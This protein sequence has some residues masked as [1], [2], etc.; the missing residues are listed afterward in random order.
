MKLYYLDNKFI[1][2]VTIH[3]SYFTG[4]IEYNSGTKNWY[5][6]GY[7]HREYGPA[8]EW[9]SGTKE[10][11]NKGKRHRIDGP[12]FEGYDGSKFWYINGE[13]ITE[14]QCNLLYDIM[15]LKGLL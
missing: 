5:V 1:K 14:L 13:Q 11:Y 9:E 12:A 3:P 4:V 15:K 2:E 8:M 6:D 10:W 7:R